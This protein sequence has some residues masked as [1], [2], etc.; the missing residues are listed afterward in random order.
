MGISPFTLDYDSTKK[1][2][3]QVVVSIMFLII[4][5]EKVCCF[6]YNYFMYKEKKGKV[7]KLYKLATRD[8]NSEALIVAGAF[9]ILMIVG[10]C[11]IDDKRFVFV[12]LLFAVICF[13]AL[14]VLLF[15]FFTEPKTAI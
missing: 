12:P 6:L 15:R 8:I 2:C 14:L 9:A 5:V 4:K 11:V 1:I 3:R 13:I 7:K 10:A